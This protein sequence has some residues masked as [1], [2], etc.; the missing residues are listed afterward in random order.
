MQGRDSFVTDPLPREKE[1]VSNEA[2]GVRINVLEDAPAVHELPDADLG[3]RAQPVGP[4][5][6]P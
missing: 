2:A 1:A 6:F 3:P 5:L 4:A